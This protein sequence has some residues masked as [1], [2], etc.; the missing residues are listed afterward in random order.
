MFSDRDKRLK[1]EKL[2]KAIKQEERQSNKGH[3]KIFLGMAAGVGKTY[4][5][6]KEAQMLTANGVD[7]TI[8][9][10]DTHGREETSLLLTGLSIIPPQKI[11]YRDKLF[12][13][14]DLDAI[15]Q[16]QPQLVIIDELAHSNIPGTHHLKRWEDVVEI[17]DN[18]IDVYTTLNIQ[19]IESLKDLVE[20]VAEVPMRETVPD[21]LFN[22]YTSLQLVDISP[23]ELLAR[24]RAGK[25]YLGAQSQIAARNFFQKKRLT[26][27]R[28]IALR[29]VAEIV[30]SDLRGMIP[31]AEGPPSSWQP[32]EKL[33]VAISQH[34]HS[35]QL[36][37]T[38]RRLAFNLDL[39]WIALHVDDHSALNDT[40]TSLLTKNIGLARDLGAEF[41]TTSDIDIV[42]GIN[43]IAHQQQASLIVVGR[44]KKSFY[45][46]KRY[47]IYERLTRECQDLDIFV[48]KE[49]ATSMSIRRSFQKIN[50]NEP[51]IE[52]LYITLLMFAIGGI[53]WTLLPYLGYKLIGLIF[54]L[55]IL[56]C[57]LIFKKGRLLAS[58]LVGAAIWSGPFIPPFNSFY[59]EAPEDIALIILYV[60][61]AAVGGI[62]VDRIREQR[63]MLIRREETSQAVYEIVHH[64]LNNPSQKSAF[65]SVEGSIEKILDGNCE[66]ISKDDNIH[67]A[68]LGTFKL[69]IDQKEMDATFWVLGNG[70]EAGHSTS[71]LPLCKNYYIPINGFDSPLGVIAYRPKEGKALSSD[72]KNFLHVVV[73]QLSLYLNRQSAEKT[74]VK[75][76]H[77]SASKLIDVA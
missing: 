39:P 34:P 29:Y 14:L 44:P 40:E 28:E 59:V 19:H 52:Y 23:D 5:M 60:V 33:L 25:V 16:R 30:D 17:L 54:L 36:I 51:L 27:L 1:A 9:L 47:S 53:S 37:R 48:V 77:D 26:A 50:E 75:R 68:P 67:K 55:G 20:S 31:M 65:S 61:T 76:D 10:I 12:D 57:S 2:L 46:P 4:A 11:N 15:L 73:Q 64:I 71:T 63:T 58:A 69:L 3:L 62:L 74:D 72:E 18:G 45:V 42:S 38:A 22:P 24:L 70:K 7:I 13:E 21:L 49:A 66:I 41:M 6:L 43:R 35:Q 32:R 8:G 56:C